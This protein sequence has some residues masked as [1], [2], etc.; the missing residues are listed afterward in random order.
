MEGYVGLFVCFSSL[1]EFHEVKIKH[2]LI[3]DQSSKNL[4]K[5]YVANYNF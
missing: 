5:K 3:K 1:L 2:V 4:I